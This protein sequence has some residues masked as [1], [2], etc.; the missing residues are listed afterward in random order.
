MGSLVAALATTQLRDYNLRGYVDPTQ[1]QN[2]PFRIPH[3]G[4][5]AELLQYGRDELIT[6]FEMMA[7]A[8][9]HWVRQFINWADFEPEQGH[10]EW[11][12]TDAIFQA[13]ETFPLEL[14]IVLVGSPGWAQ[15]E[16]TLGADF[17]PP[18]FPD[19]F[20]D[21]AAQFA[22]RYGRQVDY[23]QIWDEPNLQ[24]G[25]GGSSPRPVDYLALLSV[26]S[27]AI[28][29]N[30]ADATII[31]GALAPTSETGPDNLSDIHY[32]RDLYRL[33]AVSYVDAFA[34]KPYGF[35]LSPDD[36][37][38]DDQ[39]LN[40][41]RMVALREVMVEH[42][43][44]KRALWA[45]HWGWNNL[46]EDWQG[47]PSI[48]GNTSETQQIVYTLSALDRA[49]REWPWLGGMILHHWQPDVPDDNPQ[50][51]FALVDQSN[52]PSAL[53]QSLSER[54]FSS[55][56][57]N[58]LYSVRNPYVTYSGTWMFGNLGA[59]IGWVQD[60]QFSLTFSGRDVAFLV[61][62]DDYVAY[63]YP[64]ID[65]QPINQLPQDVAGN[66]YLILRSDT[67]QPEIRLVTITRGLP[68]HTYTM[69][70]IADE[71]VPD[72]AQNRWPLVGIAV[73]SGDLR[74]P[75]ERQITAAW[76]T[77]LI[78]VLGLLVAALAVNWKPVLSPLAFI[79]IR[80][81]KVGQLLLSAVASLVLMFSLLLTYS[82]GLPTLFRRDSVQLGLSILTSGLLYFNAFGVVVA[83]I[84]ALI[85]FVIIYNHLEIGLMLTIFWGPFFLFPVELYRFAFP[86]VEIMILITTSAWVVRMLVV[87]AE[88]RRSANS[89]IQKTTIALTVSN[90]TV[91]DYV[92][93][94]W[95]LLGCLSLL[96][97]AQPGL[98]FTE[99][100]TLFIEPIFFYVIFRTIRP[101]RQTILGIVDALVLAGFLVAVLGLFMWLRGEAIITAEGGTL[102]LASVYGSPNNVGLLLGRCVP[103]LLA[104]LLLDR[105]RQIIVGIM[106]GFVGV[107]LLLSQSAGALFLGVPVAVGG[108]ILLVWRRR[109]VLPLGGLVMVLLIGALIASNSPRF[110]RLLDFSEGTNFY[111]IRVWQSTFNLLEDYPVTGIGL[112]QFLSQFRGTYIMPDAWEEPELSHPHNI[113]L[114]FWV[115]LGLAGVVLLLFTQWAFWQRMWRQYSAQQPSDTDKLS[116]MLII[117]TMGCMLNLLAHGMVDNSIYVVDL[118]YIWMLLL[119][120]AASNFGAIDD[121]RKEMV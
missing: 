46:P 101:D 22:Q 39:T 76:L 113:I 41:S 10:Y 79:W 32:L 49:E 7:D 17:S 36:R 30:D 54:T 63:L 52:Q 29:S 59:D 92:V 27:D 14:V 34:A 115:R 89:E 42:E 37:T 50:W 43:D 110:S 80:L 70:V 51:G 4:V 108:V 9:V 117:G 88:D 83:V 102:R 100:R 1:T 3:F 85:L 106:L 91:I 58:G 45:S 99:L 26:T 75:Y 65:G 57:S 53:L 105:P 18:E 96:W 111:R 109:A 6:Q 78:A 62:E 60:S 13:I 5:N 86:M 104:Y 103:F 64:S 61:R 23:Y 19:E 38:V 68:D 98:A 56:A 31:A 74:A 119:G 121:S 12:A 82:D 120:I 71:L 81:D 72:E 94:S 73:S 35:E 112:D 87:W 16:N 48:W 93:M 33:G 118:I 11:A 47:Q 66:P 44:G 97:T 114:D 40:F 84:A 28:R 21:F 25:W 107:A 24:S 2:L 69:Q 8:N 116:L 15:R 20:A 55:A 77:T 90:V 95:F 67:L